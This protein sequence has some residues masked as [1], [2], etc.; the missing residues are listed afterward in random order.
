LTTPVH[1][2]LHHAY[3]DV[4]RPM[5]EELILKNQELLVHEAKAKGVLDMVIDTGTRAKISDEW[6]RIDSKA[7]LDDG[8]ARS[9]AKWEVMRS[10]LAGQG[11]QN[12]KEIVFALMYPR[13]DINVSKQL[14]H[15]LKSPFCVHPK[16]GKVCVPMDPQTCE[17]FDLDAVPTMNSLVQQIAEMKIDLRLLK[18][19]SDE[20][21]TARK[22]VKNTSL[23][24]YVTLFEASFLRP[25]Q[26]SIRLQRR[27]RKQDG[28]QSW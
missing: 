24:E 9:K 10:H 16:T 2:S 12:E 3:K 8:Y 23:K 1:P 19:S 4:L 21:K 6:K 25:L 13:L 17:R 26:Q 14:N 22:A 27:K 15:L 28:D 7:K 5:F 11:E 20:S 18:G